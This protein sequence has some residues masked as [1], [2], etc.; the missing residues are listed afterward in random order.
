M[1]LKAFAT[2]Q[3]LNKISFK[4]FRSSRNKKKNYG[5]TYES[6]M[7]PHIQCQ[8][9]LYTSQI[10]EIRHVYQHRQSCVY[11]DMQQSGKLLALFALE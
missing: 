9:S 11:N 5:V 8:K 10:F 3:L 6:P 7:N 4:I 2:T 1:L